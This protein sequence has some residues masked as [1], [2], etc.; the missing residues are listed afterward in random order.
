M[1]PFKRLL[2]YAK[3]YKVVLLFGILA[4][5]AA[6]LLKAAV[7]LAIQQSVDALA[8]QITHSQ[9]LL[10]SVVVIALGLLQ[11]GFAFAQS[12][13]LLGAAHSMERDIR[14]S[15][16]EH[17]QKLPLEFF[18]VNRTG[19]L[20]TQATRDVAQA[21]NASAEALMYSVNTIVSLMII[22]PLMALL[23]WR[24]TLLAFAPMLL[25]LI[26]TLAFQRPMRARYA[27]VAESYARM[28]VEAHEALCAV[29]TVRA[30]LQESAAVGAFTNLSRQCVDYQLGAV[31]LYNLLHPLLEFFVGL[32]VIAVLWYG[33]DL[34]ASGTLSIGQ[35]LEFILYIGY[36]AWP[37]HSLGRELAV[38]QRGAVSMRR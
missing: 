3:P 11:G 30:Y 25:V 18:Q 32:S 35:F 4:L 38:L 33:G 17:L 12:R 23:S 28:C 20:M 29:K 21:A 14:N 8:G 10:Y 1:I 34:T 36:L 37:M 15:F 19:E 24:L 9:L 2:T 13:L 31:R 26:A 16:Y 27:K 22:L 7:P 6:N 5:V